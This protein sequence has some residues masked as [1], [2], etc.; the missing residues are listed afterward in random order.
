MVHYYLSHPTWGITLKRDNVEETWD[1]IT[2]AQTA[3]Y[4]WSGGHSRVPA[5]GS[6]ATRHRYRN[7]LDSDERLERIYARHR[8]Q[9]ERRRR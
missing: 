3:Q 2:I 5:K 8:V 1:A 9:S 7:L 4:A 6:G